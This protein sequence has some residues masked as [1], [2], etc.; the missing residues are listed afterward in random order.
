MHIAPAVLLVLA[1]GGG[2]PVAPMPEPHGYLT[3]VPLLA[4]QPAGE[5]FHRF[6]P[7][8][9]GRAPAL[10]ISAGYWLTPQ[11]GVEGELT[12]GR[13]VSAPQQFSYTWREDFTAYSRDQLAML[14]VRWRPARGV[15]HLVAGG[16]V[17]RST[18]GQRDIVTTYIFQTGQ[19]TVRE[20]D[21]AETRLDFRLTAGFDLAL[22]VH[23][24]AAVVP[25]FRV[26]TIDRSGMEYATYMGMGAVRYDVGMGLRAMF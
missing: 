9:S 5:P 8:L 24:R 3:A 25:T 14:L 2:A 6:S 4:V 21:W 22:P 15:F 26:R 13:A 23:R 10:L 18:I 1:Q 19:P 7:P 17:T 12:L 11:F 20:A 16:G